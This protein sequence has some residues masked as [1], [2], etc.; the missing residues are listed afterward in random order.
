MEDSPL[1]GRT[2]NRVPLNDLTTEEREMLACENLKLAYYWAKRFCF[3]RRDR[4]LCEEAAL[5]G[6]AK[7]VM[8]WNP[9][10]GFNFSTYAVYWIRQSLGRAMMI[11]RRHGF[12]YLNGAKPRKP[13]STIRA[14]SGDEM[15]VDQY[16][17]DDAD[18]PET[19][20][21]WD[22]MMA[23]LNPR[24]RFVIE[25]RYVEDLTLDEAGKVLGVT[26]ERVR[27]IE[28]SAMR[29]LKI[30]CRDLLEGATGLVLPFAPKE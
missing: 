26:R 9:E 6:L 3:N 17:P 10:Y 13:I 2:L 8:H 24:Q 15:T 5:F 12:M 21:L 7:A 25:L 19:S 30:R 22:K 23:R 18:P 16:V 1:D 4:D 27:Q 20:D 29:S 11:E 14:P 28:W